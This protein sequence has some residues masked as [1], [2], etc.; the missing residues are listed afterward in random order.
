MIKKTIHFSQ[1]AYLSLRLQQLIVKPADGSDEKSL[2]IEDIGMVVLEHPQLT[3]SHGLMGALLA[4]GAAIVTC[5]DKYMPSGLL[6]NLD[7]HH[8]QSARFK[9]QIEAS[10]PLKKQLWQQTIKAKIQNQAAHLRLRGQSPDA[11]LHLAKE[12]NSGDTYNREALA[13]ARYW[14]ALFGEDFIRDPDGEAPN[15]LLNYGY[16]ILRATVARGLVASGLLP[17]F[18]IHH[19]NQYNA[20]CLADDIMEPYRPLVDRLVY[21]IWRNQPDTDDL[22]ISPKLKKSLLGIPAMDIRIDGYGS[23]L[24]VGLQR[25]T[26]SLVA[27]LEGSSRRLI[28]PE[29]L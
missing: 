18:G 27:C 21:D 3:L 29:F 13:A 23:P 1:P 20:Y 9:I 15:I 19:H 22:I 17:T 26:N 8:L 7:G 4:N 2:P 5:S 16:A 11:L 28:Y 24:M 10:E 12:V 6:L 14:K 25:T